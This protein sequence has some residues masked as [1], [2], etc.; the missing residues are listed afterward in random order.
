MALGPWIGFWQLH[1][2]V[3]ATT[4]TLIRALTRS[5][6]SMTHT[7]RSSSSIVAVITMM[8]ICTMMLQSTINGV[9]AAPAEI[10]VGPL[11]REEQP[12]GNGTGIWACRYM[13]TAIDEAFT[14]AVW[15]SD[16]V[17]I[18]VE[19]GLYQVIRCDMLFHST[20]WSLTMMAINR[21]VLISVCSFANA[22]VNAS[23]SVVILPC[24]VVYTSS[25]QAVHPCT[26][27]KSWML[28][29]VL[30]IL[31]GKDVVVE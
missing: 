31:R 6:P 25:A 9:S 19:P 29:L 10:T 8:I 15:P 17:I 27:Y 23:P 2:S 26:G 20:A 5:S 22:T 3:V 18:N 12:C 4:M 30:V 16:P 24:Q 7:R 28:L 13:R 14:I 21:L 1:P 11:G